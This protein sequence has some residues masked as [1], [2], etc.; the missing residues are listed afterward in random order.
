MNS[1]A[2]GT[3]VVSIQGSEDA[4]PSLSL[5]PYGS[6]GDGVDDDDKD[7]EA[8]EGLAALDVIAHPSELGPQGIPLWKIDVLLPIWILI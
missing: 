8:L 7:G 6:Q 2:V 5:S 4:L 3:H 1:T